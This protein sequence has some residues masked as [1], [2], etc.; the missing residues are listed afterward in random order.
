[1]FSQLNFNLHQFKAFSLNFTIEMNL[2][3]EYITLFLLHG[4]LRHENFSVEIRRVGASW[5]EGGS[6]EFIMSTSSTHYLM[7]FAPQPHDAGGGKKG[8]KFTVSRMRLKT[9]WKISTQDINSLQLDSSLEW[10]YQTSDCNLSFMV[11]AERK[12][13]EE[14]KK[15]CWKH[16]SIHSERALRQWWK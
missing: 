12:K 5:L 2:F 9:K 10:N 14:E 16:F 1:M 11:I 15:M 3:T 6:R 4:N 8:M 13:G 7:V